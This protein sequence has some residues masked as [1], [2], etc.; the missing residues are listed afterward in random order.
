[1]K[2][3]QRSGPYHLIGF[4]MGGTIA[5]E[6]AGQLHDAGE[7]VAF[8]AL[9]DLAANTSRGPHPRSRRAACSGVK[10]RRG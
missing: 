9:L 5:W 8:L 10:C 7:Q 4:S 1:M 6:M 3:V 2:T